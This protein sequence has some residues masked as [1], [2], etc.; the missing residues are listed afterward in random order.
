M[1]R[2]L[3]QRAITLH[4]TVPGFLLL[5]S[6]RCWRAN[7]ILTELITNASRHA[8]DTQGGRISV[9]VTTAGG[10]IACRVSDDGRAAPTPEPGLGT[11]LVDALT[12]D[13]GGDVERIYTQSGTIVT[14]SFPRNRGPAEDYLNSSF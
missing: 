11:H 1:S 2:D 12:A 4:L 8:F 5:G 10:W 7:L 9:A 3:D 13:L 14:L 6:V